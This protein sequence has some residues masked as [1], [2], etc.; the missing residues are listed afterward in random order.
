M[1]T[2][3]IQGSSPEPYTTTFTRNGANLT[4][5][6]TCP[7]GGVGQYC[8]H[9]L[10]ILR[11]SAEGVISTNVGD[12]GIVRSWLP[13]TDVDPALKEFDEAEQAEEAAKKR[14]ALAKKKLARALMN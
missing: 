11:G 13:G 5:H 10:R 6:C 3:K 14:F 2:F 1:I 12:V 8:K 9:R 4:A 7:A